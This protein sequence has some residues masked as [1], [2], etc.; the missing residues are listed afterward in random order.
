MRKQDVKGLSYLLW[1][2]VRGVLWVVALC[3]IIPSITPKAFASTIYVPKDYPTI[4]AA[5]IGAAAG[6]VIRVGPGQWCGARISKQLELEGEGGATIIGCPDGLPGPVS[7]F[8]GRFRAGFFLDAGASGSAIRHFTFDGRGWSAADT[9]PLAVGLVGRS[10]RAP[11]N[12]ITVEYNQ[13]LGCLFGFESSGSRWQVHHNVFDGFTID[14]VTGFGGGAILMNNIRSREANNEVSFNKITTTIPVGDLPSFIDG[15]NIP[16]VGLAVAAQDGLVLTNNQISI[17]PAPGAT[18]GAA[19]ILIT[20]GPSADTGEDLT[21]INSVI[22]N[23]DGRGITYAL[24]ITLD[25]F[26]GTGNTVNATLRGNFGVNVINTTTS[27]VRNRAIQT[28]LDCDASGA[29]P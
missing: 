12:D 6:D 10:S 15:F 7:A 24:L 5:V 23:N 21:S 22:V 8:F 9:T 18:G 11:A 4:Q 19:G 27:N 28:L 2:T 20:D 14:P 29:C 17:T 26:G 16:F 25:L 3:S 13:F 1:Y